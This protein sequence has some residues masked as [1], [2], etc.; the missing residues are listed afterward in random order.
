VLPSCGVAFNRLAACL[1]LIAPELRQ[2]PAPAQHR[3]HPDCCQIPDRPTELNHRAKKPA[4]PRRC[5]LDNHQDG[6]AQFA[7]DADALEQAQ[8]DEQNRGRD[9]DLLISW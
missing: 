8:E 3:E 5:V 1:S 6:S 9:A 2:S 7:A 4:V